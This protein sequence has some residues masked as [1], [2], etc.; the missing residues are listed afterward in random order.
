MLEIKDLKVFIGSLYI[1]QGISLSVHKGE[2][3]YLLG[4]NGAGKTTL[5]K[6]II[7][8]IKPSSGSIAMNGIDITREPTYVRAKLGIRYVPDNKRLFMSLSVEENLYTAL[9][10]S[11][12]SKDK[13]IERI[14][15]IYNVFPDLKRLRKLKASQLSGG[16]QQMLNLARILAL[17]NTKILLV[18]EPVEGLSPMFVSKILDALMRLVEEGLSMIIVETRPVL[19][20]KINGRYIILNG[21]KIVS[22]GYTEDLLKNK[23]LIE[24]YL[25]LHKSD[26]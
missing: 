15:Y 11:G 10:A 18:D 14:E 6:T 2:I 21:G 12:L 17:P 4:R 24:T 16:Q 1:L 5:L 20:E 19:M 8:F 25:G 22:E 13:A 26:K 7:G 3:I 23:I 9:L